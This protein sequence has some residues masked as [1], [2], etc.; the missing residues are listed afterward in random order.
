MLSN[1]ILFCLQ[2]VET[3]ESKHPVHGFFVPSKDDGTQN[4]KPRKEVNYEY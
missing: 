2:L 4:D 1:R 3:K